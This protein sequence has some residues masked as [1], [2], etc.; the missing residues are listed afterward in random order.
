MDA[1]RYVIVLVALTP[2]PVSGQ[3]LAQTPSTD[4]I[5]VS[6][7]RFKVLLE[8]AHERVI[9]YVLRPDRS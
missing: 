7:D 3:A 9:E 4:V 2:L 8:N 1:I 5:S 6:P